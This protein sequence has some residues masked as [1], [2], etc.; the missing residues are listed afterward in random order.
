M[1]VSLE[2]IYILNQND[3]YFLHNQKILILLIYF[4]IPW[5]ILII[6]NTP[7]HIVISCDAL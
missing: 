6:N 2:D 4:L 1:A 5:N 7:R 3:V